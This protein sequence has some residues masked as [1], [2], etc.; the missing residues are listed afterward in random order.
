MAAAELPKG[1]HLRADFVAGLYMCNW[2]IKL[3]STGDEYILFLTYI[4]DFMYVTYFP[5]LCE[6]LKDFAC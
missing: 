1:Y 6:M 4:R 2:P 3:L 5:V